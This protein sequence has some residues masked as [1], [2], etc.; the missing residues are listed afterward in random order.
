MIDDIEGLTARL[1]AALARQEEA[2]DLERRA[3]LTLAEA[4]EAIEDIP[5]EERDRAARDRAETVWREAQARL[6]EA[7]EDRALIEAEVGLLDPAAVHLAYLRH[8]RAG[9]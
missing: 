3:A 7:R 9:G 8:A 4:E 2:A 5:R 1:V 6:E